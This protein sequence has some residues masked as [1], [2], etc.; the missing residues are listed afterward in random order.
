MTS[1]IIKLHGS[2]TYQSDPLI[3]LDEEG[4]ALSKTPRYTLDQLS[5][6]A[7]RLLQKW[8]RSS[9]GMPRNELVARNKEASILLQAFLKSQ[10]GAG[11]LIPVCRQI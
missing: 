3:P 8:R 6:N 7:I 10:S 4:E 5:P 1:P 11:E 9:N 2:V